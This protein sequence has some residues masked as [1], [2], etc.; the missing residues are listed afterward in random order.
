MLAT[1]TRV[2]VLLL[3]LLLLVAA[4]ARAEPPDLLA[5]RAPSRLNG[6]RNA[7]VLTDGV[8]APEGDDWSTDVTA[9]FLSSSAY[10]EYDL[11]RVQPIEA[12]YLQGDNND[13]YLVQVS[14]DGKHF[15]DL[16]LAASLGAPGLRGRSVST[17]HGSAR[18]VR[19][20][21]RK[22]DGN[23]SLAELAL[24]SSRP[25]HLPPE[26]EVREG[27]GY[28][29]RLRNALLGFGLGL[30]I[31]LFATGR[32]SG[33][34]WLALAALAPLASGYVLWHA[35]VG[36]WPVQARELSL[37]RALTAAVAGLALLREGWFRPRFAAHR[38]VVLGVLAL[39]GGLAF[40]SF[41]NLGRSQFWNSLEGRPE[42]V[43]TTDMR[44]YYPFAK[45]F[46][47]LG[48]D[49]VYLA[50][51]Q[52]YLE[53][54]PGATLASV[55][56]TVVRD[57]NDHSIH[58]LRELAE[59]LRQVRARFSAPRWRSFK[60]DMRYFRE[61]MGPDYLAT[62]SDHGAN[63]TPV[64]VLFARLFFGSRL[65]SEQ[66]LLMGGLL[67]LMLFALMFAVVWR[68]F[69]LRPMLVSMV[70][71][72]ANDF[73]MFGTNWGGAT[74]RHDWLVYLGFGVCALHARRF[75]LAGVLFGL[76]VMIRAFPGAALIG[77]TATLGFWVVE[78]WRREGRPPALRALLAQ[79][80]PALL[81]LAGAAGCML[82]LL[83][84]TTAL[85]SPGAWIA[86]WHKV[87]LLNSQLAVND[88]SLKALIGGLE[89][90]DKTLRARL[91]LY[92]CALLVCV[93]VALFA[94]RGRRLD[95]AAVLALPLI[96][97]L[98]NP[99]N[100]YDHFVCLL[101]LLGTAAGREPLA[102]PASEA[103]SPSLARAALPWLAVCVAQYWTVLDPDLGRHFQSSTALLFAG[104]GWYYLEALGATGA[105][106]N[107]PAR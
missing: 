83:L 64:W 12:G 22:G 52:A 99:S 103:A 30:V 69:G 2:S 8:V 23:Y 40:A 51:A 60:R 42:F 47:E 20:S 62:L 72:G 97:V 9:V 19:V 76:S 59:P 106:G 25:S 86:W 46:E 92:L 11:G 96:P 55:G 70:V 31:M 100:Y 107:A 63:A 77:V 105:L 16:W 38:G 34:L 68:S 5:G 56:N 33:P 6:V 91:P 36:A 24:Y 44:V 67:D 89:S 14:G 49:G 43:H 82:V 17:L 78:Q 32:R 45:Y 102:A 79:Q 58:R 104:I 93:A 15:T 98:A 37:L 29:P 10:V 101:P 7:R 26:L 94:G 1:H 61:V 28:G 81:V 65:A 35:L 66:V 85:Y 87:T 13:A 84:L 41:Y 48:Y 74:L 3:P 75:V 73:Y 53:D 57:L 4:Q 54:V 80:R 21:P 71:F 27:V 95:Q 39:C 90:T 88:E 18:F 50:S